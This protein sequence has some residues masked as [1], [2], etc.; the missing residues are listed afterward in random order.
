VTKNIYIFSG[1][2]ANERVFQQL[3]LSGYST[4]FIRWEIPGKHETIENYATRLLPQITTIRPTLIGLSFG[5]LI[6]V[7]I[8]K[9]ID[10][11]NVILIA[12]VK[13]KSEIPLYYRW[14]GKLRLHQLLPTHLLKET[15]LFS[16][17]V[18]RN[19]TGADKQVLKSIFEGT[20][21]VFLKWA[22][23]EA[24]RWKNQKQL[25]NIRHIH[26]TADHIFPFRYVSC[27]IKIN[28]GGH[29]LTLQNANEIS[30]ILRTNIQISK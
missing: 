20:N 19:S 25:E 13:T 17:W 18:F 9:Q 6:S 4:T 24:V 5:G 26:G 29:L 21:P 15:N 2:G 30:K 28:D 3:D 7:E 8:A 23:S 22:I 27:D 10:T 14:A 16:N 1:L 11:E 12:S